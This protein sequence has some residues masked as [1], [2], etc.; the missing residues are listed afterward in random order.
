MNSSK[1]KFLSIQEVSKRFNVNKST[2]RFWER[3]LD[4]ILLP[5]RTQGRQRRYG[6][7][8]LAIIEEIMMMKRAGLSL[9]EIRRK[10][11]GGVM[12]EIGTQNGSKGAIDQIDQLA[13]RVADVVRSE[14]LR[15]LQG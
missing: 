7:E 11:S 8:H 10:L 3:E 2:L 13:Q 5:P 6:P 15:F 9:D 4:G 12:P 14:I 1:Q